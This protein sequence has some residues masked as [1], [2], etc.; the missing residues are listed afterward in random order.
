MAAQNIN[1]GIH[2]GLTCQYL[3]AAPTALSM[4]PRM[5]LVDMALAIAAV[6]VLGG[7][8]LAGAP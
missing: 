2:A 5:A 7:G 8:A 3:A 1:V 4:R 6:A